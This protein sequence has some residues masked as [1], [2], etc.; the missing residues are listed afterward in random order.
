MI[1]GPS[2]LKRECSLLQ[3]RCCGE[4]IRVVDHYRYLGITFQSSLSF[5]RHIM[6]TI[7]VAKRAT[8][9]LN[10]C[11]AR[12][13]GLRPRTRIHL[14]N[15]LVRPILEYGMGLISPILPQYLKN[16][17]QSIQT[18]FL[19]ETLRARNQ[20]LYFLLSECGQEDLQA[21]WDK[22]LMSLLNRIRQQ[23][24]ES[25][26]Q[27]IYYSLPWIRQMLFV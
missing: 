6:D 26:C 7:K 25:I 12:H 15:T 17:L 4:L 1:V 3:F 5:H 13:S 9:R 24:D 22:A 10:Y 21:R 20:P 2:S 18:Q 19:R 27:R 8:G 11:F 16:Q 14:W 23:P